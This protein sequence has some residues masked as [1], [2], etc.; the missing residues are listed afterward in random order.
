MW[1]ISKTEGPKWL[2]NHE[3]AKLTVQLFSGA[4]AGLIFGEILEKLEKSKK[5]V[6]E[7]VKNIL[8]EISKKKFKKLR[9]NFR[10]RLIKF[11]YEI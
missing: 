4:I 10:E 7:I 11:R 8:P 2:K 1:P 3:Q 9:K 6:T 5:I